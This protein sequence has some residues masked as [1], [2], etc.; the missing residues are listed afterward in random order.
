MAPNFFGFEV[1]KPAGDWSIAMS[2]GSMSA[3]DH[4]IGMFLNPGES[5]PGRGFVWLMVYGF[6]ITL[7]EACRSPAILT[8]SMNYEL[9]TNKVTSKFVRVTE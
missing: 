6:N 2:A 8:F 3:L 7:T 1:L 9:R 4:A 5:W